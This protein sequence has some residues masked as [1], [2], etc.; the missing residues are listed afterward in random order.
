MT[1]LD[2]VCDLRERLKR[3]GDPRKTGR[4]EDGEVDYVSQIAVTDDD[5]PELLAIAREWVEIT[6]W[7][8]DEDDVSVFAP[9]HA[10]RCLAQL[11]APETIDLLTGM[12]DALDA[13]DD[14]WYME[15]FPHVFAWMGPAAL[16]PLRAYLADEAHRDWPRVAAASGL[17]HLAARHPETRDEVVPA[18]TAALS[19]FEVNDDTFNAVIISYLMDLKASETYELIE[20]AYAADRVDVSMNG[21]WNTVREEL[22]IEGLGLVPK[23]LASQT[24][25]WLPAGFADVVERLAE[26][27]PLAFAPEP[28]P[29]FGTRRKIGRNEPCPCGSG[30]KYKKCCGR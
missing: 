24:W 7:P 5:V 25:Q 28:A 18:L 12:M 15:E 16:A 11:Q 30:K 8:E 10:W 4:W 23:D 22:G 6:E 9:V 17:R 2:K 20:R 29:P 1:E 19:D 27:P 14:D 3:F 13:D 26:P 21:N